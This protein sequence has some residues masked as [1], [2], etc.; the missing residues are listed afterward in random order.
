MIYSWLFVVL[1]AD[2][3]KAY[4]M[5][6]VFFCLH[7]LLYN[8]RWTLINIFFYNWWKEWNSFSAHLIKNKI[9]MIF[10]HILFWLV[11]ILIVYILFRYHEYTN[12][13]IVFIGSLFIE[14]LALTNILFNI[15]ISWLFKSH[16]LIIIIGILIMISILMRM[17]KQW[18][19]IGIV[20][21]V[22]YWFGS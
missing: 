21:L 1:N 7:A 6:L 12:A 2:E 3:R 18:I 16:S 14:K 20:I 4:M 17:F 9:F 10:L 13:T 11:V 8:N 19:K 5:I 22:L 15:S